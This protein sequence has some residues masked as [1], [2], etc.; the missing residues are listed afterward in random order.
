MNTLIAA[1]AGVLAVLG[2]VWLAWRFG[3]S[4]GTATNEA[5]SSSAALKIEQRMDRAATDA[6]ADLDGIEDTLRRGEF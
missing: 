1:G 6:P 4:A 3:K 5:D 2:I